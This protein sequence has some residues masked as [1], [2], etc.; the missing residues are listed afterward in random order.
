M[1]KITIRNLSADLQELITDRMNREKCNSA[2]AV[3]AILDDAAIE[4]TVKHDIEIMKESWDAD[5]SERRAPAG[6]CPCVQITI[7]CRQV[8]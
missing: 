2:A 6:G 1:K 3:V 5:V 8:S 4:R 7:H